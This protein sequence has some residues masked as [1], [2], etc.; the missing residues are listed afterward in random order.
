MADAALDQQVAGA[1]QI[2]MQG[3]IAEAEAI[4]RAVLARDPRHFE[5]THLLGLAALQTGQL[6]LAVETLERAVALD[7]QSAKARNN[8]GNAL[9]ASGQLD[10][11]A[12]RFAEARSLDPSLP[13]I[14]FNHGVVLVELGR[15]EE[16]AEC[17]SRAV[18]QAPDDAEALNNLGTALHHLGRQAGALARFEEAVAARPGLAEAH[19]GRGNALLEMHRAAESLAAYDHALA[20]RPALAEAWYNR[21]N[22]LQ[23]LR[24]LDEAVASYARAAA[25]KPGD[26][27][28]L[29]VALHAQMKLCDWTELDARRA[30]VEA[31]VLRG[32]AVSSPYS[33]LVLCGSRTVQRAA[34]R[35]WIARRA[36]AQS[37]PPAVARNGPRIAIGYFSADLHDHATTRL[38]AEMFERHDPSRFRILAFSFGPQKEDAMRARLRAAFDEFIDVSTMQDRAIAELARARG[39]DVAVDLKGHTQDSR[40]GIFAW[41]AAPVQVNH[42][43]YPGTIAAPYMDYLIADHVLI[44]PG[45]AAD[46]A[47]KIVWLPGSYQPNDRHR[48][49]ADAPVTRRENG[50]PEQGFVFCGFNASYKITPAIFDIWMRLLRRVP[51]S[52]LWLFEDNRWAP[53]NL[54]R[55]AAARGVD[56]A[57]LVF[58]PPMEPARHL[59]RHAAADIFLDTLPVN[60]HTTASDALW[61]GLPVLTMP[62]ESLVGRVAASLLH[63]AGLPELIAA[64]AEDYEALA[65][66]LATDPDRLAATRAKLAAQRMTCALFDAALFTHRIEAA[67]EAMVARHRAGL[68][69]APFEVAP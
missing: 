37:T 52:V 27:F 36:P 66:A 50:L 49:I 16:A 55:E 14:D 26:T 19:A 12:S 11:A 23:E 40:P 28:G 39:L 29:E 51:G 22:A 53:A 2:H 57:R 6:A 21:G 63:A 46:Y 10:N 31:K 64:T 38:M 17:L 9:R 1:R 67:Y 5:A 56:P 65:F 25:L 61:A 47:E 33:V 32:E 60:A 68:P 13:G 45:H 58:A 7:P 30:A 48:A 41:R 15:H 18:A 69:P 34:S 3:R 42:L 4:Y 35:N 44:P 54:R 20:L 59:A 62:G 8:L 43:G 24:R